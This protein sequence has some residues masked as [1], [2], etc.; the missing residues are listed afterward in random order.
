MFKVEAV[1]CV[2]LFQMVCRARKLIKLHIIFLTKENKYKKSKYNNLNEVDNEIK[3]KAQTYNE[4]LTNYNV[5]YYNNDQ[6]FYNYDDSHCFIASID[7]IFILMI[8]IILLYR[9]ILLIF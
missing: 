7:N 5:V 3:E 4:I 9:N 1:D 6:K 8:C 2:D